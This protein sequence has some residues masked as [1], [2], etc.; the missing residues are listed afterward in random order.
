VTP[1]WVFMR[2]R[3]LLLRAWALGRRDAARAGGRPGEGL[4]RTRVRVRSGSGAG[5]GKGEA[6]RGSGRLDGEVF[7]YHLVVVAAGEQAYAT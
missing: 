4:A 6:S 5:K 2:E 7:D 3:M 1:T